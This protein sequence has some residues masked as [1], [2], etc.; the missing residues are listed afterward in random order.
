MPGMTG[1][2]LAEILPVPRPRVVFL[3]AFPEHALEAF[4]IGAAHYLLKPVT[5]EEVAQA[6][7]RLFPVHPQNAAWFRISVRAK[8]RL[9]VEG[10][11]G[12][13]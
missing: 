2:E 1:M 6:L 8:G 3:T 11:M 7:S 5:R 10:T 9:R 4:R 12:H 13:G